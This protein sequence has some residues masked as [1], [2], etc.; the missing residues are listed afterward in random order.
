MIALIDLAQACVLFG[1]Q[2]YKAL[3]MCYNNMANLHYKHQKY[4]LAAD[5]F[6]KAWHMASL[7]LGDLEPEAF[8]RKFESERPKPGV[9][10]M[11]LPAELKE[12]MARKH[13]LIVK[14]HRFYQFA[15][16]LY[17]VWRYKDGADLL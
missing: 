4:Q 11:P 2:N 13:L 1:G 5:S 15:M 17:K 9:K 7:C 3:G 8:Y 14:A 12:S 10:I 16:C 6:N